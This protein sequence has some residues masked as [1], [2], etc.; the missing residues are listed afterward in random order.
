MKPGAFTGLTVVRMATLTSGRVGAA[1]NQL[2]PERAAKDGDSKEAQPGR[3]RS[4][5]PRAASW[6]LDANPGT[7]TTPPF[8]PRVSGWRNRVRRSPTHRQ[9]CRPAARVQIAIGERHQLP[10]RRGL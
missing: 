7:C 2:D 8:P 6:I 3:S 1:L 9:A 4:Q 10:V 5:T